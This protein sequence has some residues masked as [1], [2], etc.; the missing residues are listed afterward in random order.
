M[1]LVLFDDYKLGVIKG[2]SVVDVRPA[3]ADL[4]HTSPQD[5]MSQLVQRRRDAPAEPAHPNHGKLAHRRLQ[6]YSRSP[7]S[8][9]FS[10][11]RRSGLPDSGFA[12]AGGAGSDQT[13]AS[14]APPGR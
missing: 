14:A 11:P 9:E 10:I 1:K 13:P 2:N 3:V 4:V 6:S 5:L 12:A 8:G 7:G